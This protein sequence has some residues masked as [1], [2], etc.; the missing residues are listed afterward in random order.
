MIRQFIK[1]ENLLLLF[2]LTAFFI[3]GLFFVAILPIFKAP[4]ELI[5]YATVKYRSQPEENQWTKIVKRDENGNMLQRHYSEE[6][7]A[8]LNLMRTPAGTDLNIPPPG[9]M[10]LHEPEILEQKWNK[11]FA[12]YP[13]MV[14]DYP[15]LYYDYSASLV[16]K[17]LIN[18]NIFVRFFSVRIFSVLLGVLILVLSYLIL[19]KLGFQKKH[20]LLM[21]A[22][23]SFQPMF[24]A[25]SAIINPDIMLILTMTAFIYGG[26]SLLKDGFNFS[27]LIIIF[28]SS[29]G[30]ILTKGPGIVLASIAAPLVA[31]ALYEKFKTKLPAKF[32][33]FVFLSI[34]IISIL[35]YSLIP[36][37]Y[38]QKITRFGEA[39]QF[40]SPLASLSKYLDVTLT[41][42]RFMIT[43]V[44]YW[45][46]FGSLEAEIPESI[47]KTI[48]FLTFLAV[49][50]LLRL[51]FSKDYPDFLPKIKFLIFFLFIIFMLQIAIRFYDWRVFDLNDKILISTPGRYFLPYVSA[52]LIL[53]LVGLGSLLKTA[54]NFEIFLK[55][56]LV[57]MVL[58]CLY[59]MFLVIIPHFYL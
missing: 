55:A 44:S 59:S 45:G 33:P 4:D 20:S 19:N 7:S 15:P 17:S 53:L 27:N 37:G 31:Y 30:G 47:I 26:V 8:T 54:R 41:E 14:T 16:E 22:I 36:Q 48:W 3:K 35:A 42:N 46:N 6:I 29:A 9:T 40:D 32:F 43:S 11:N 25:T 18:H 13:P 56:S 38:V 24:S 51:A 58:L 5:H 49:I 21:T 1:K 2:I 39:S 57:A 52:H 34:F 23:I 50:G 10:G 12:T 28:L